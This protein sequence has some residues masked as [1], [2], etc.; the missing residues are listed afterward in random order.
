MGILELSNFIKEQIKASGISKTEVARR[1]GICKAE[2][3]KLLRG[4]IRQSKITT[5]VSLAKA[6][7]VHPFDLISSFLK[8]GDIPDN[9]SQ[10][11]DDK[12]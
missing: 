6:L 2:L 10:T 4:D 1:A 5:F 8:G 11:R 3:Y 12:S 9:G 7:Q